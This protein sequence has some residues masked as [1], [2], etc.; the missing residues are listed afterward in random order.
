MNDKYGHR[1]GDEVLKETWKS[2]VHSLE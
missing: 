1:K 2:F